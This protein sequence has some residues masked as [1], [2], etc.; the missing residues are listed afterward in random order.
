MRESHGEGLARHADPEP[1]GGRRKADAEALEGAHAGQVS[2]CEITRTG[3]PT[4]LT[5]AEG[6]TIGGDN[7]ESPMGSAQSQTLKKGFAFRRMC[8]NSLHGNREAPEASAGEDGAADRSEKAMSRASDV[9]ASGESDGRVVPEQ[10]AKSQDQ[11]DQ[12]FWSLYERVSAVMAR[13][14]DESEADGGRR[15]IVGNTDGPAAPR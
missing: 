13:R 14:T 1:C 12:G 6:N 5:E 2:S 3:T 8:G 9:Y 4:P 15:P 7:G 11:R 10:P